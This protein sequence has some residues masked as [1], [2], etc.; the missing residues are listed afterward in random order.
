MMVL[1]FCRFPGDVKRIC[2]TLFFTVSC[3][4]RLKRDLKWFLVV[5]LIRHQ[6]SKHSAIKYAALS[7]FASK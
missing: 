4:K 1:L 2:I 7:S 5:Y 6:D 3:S